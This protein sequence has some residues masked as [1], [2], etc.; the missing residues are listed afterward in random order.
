MFFFVFLRLQTMICT[1]LKKILYIGL[2]MA[3]ML[4]ASCGLKLK[5][6]E[7]GESDPRLEVRRYDRLESRYLT[8][9]DYSALQE[10]NIEYPIETRTLL[11]KVLQLGNVDDP[12]INNRFLRYYQDTTLQTIVADVQVTFAKIDDV[13]SQLAEAFGQLKSW[14]PKLPI[15]MFYAQ[16]GALD[17]SIVVGNGTV[18]IC[19]D[20]YLGVNYPI[21]KRYYSWSQRQLMDRRY[22]VADCLIFYLLSLYPMPNYDARSQMEKDLHMG[23]VMWVANKALGK[24]VFCTRYVAMVN[25]YMS[26]QKHH[27]MGALLRLDDYSGMIK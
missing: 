16:I 22:I 21:Y 25:A 24:P 26:R 20:K 10:M 17:Q 9:G 12:E 11:E 6:S 14:V 5:P 23:K 2:V 18:G 3:A 8:T 1:K 19:L 15:P 4:C 27:D 13:N 7:W